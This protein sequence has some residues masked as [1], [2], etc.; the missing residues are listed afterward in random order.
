MKLRIR[1]SSIRLRLQQG[2]VRALLK[3]GHVE[4][5]TR[6]GDAPEDVLV[7]RLEVGPALTTTWRGGRLAVT[8][9]EKT[10]EAWARG[11]GLTL[12]TSRPFPDGSALSLLIE[13]DL[14]CLKPREGENDDDA[15]PNPRTC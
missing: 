9:D 4:E 3:V 8:L 12:E 15:Y 6:L 1:G 2:E 11:E 7:Y 13:K 14:A 5:R 10:V